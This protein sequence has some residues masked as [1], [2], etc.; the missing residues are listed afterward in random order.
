MEYFYDLSVHIIPLNKELV[1]QEIKK[2]QQ[3]IKLDYNERKKNKT[4]NQVLY[5]KDV[6][7][8]EIDRMS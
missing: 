1:L 3:K 5:E 2:K 4:Y 8:E 7:E 6:A